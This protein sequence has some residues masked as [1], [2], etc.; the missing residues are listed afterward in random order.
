MPRFLIGAPGRRTVAVLTTGGVFAALA[1]VQVGSA[2]AET[3]PGQ[4][5]LGCTTAG[6][7]SSYTVPVTAD[8]TPDPATAGAALALQVQATV[9]DLA[10]LA[11]TVSGVHL[12]LPIPA[13]VDHV[14]GVTFTGGNLTGSQ[15]VVGSTVEL[16][17]AGPA[18]SGTVQLPAFTV[19]VVLRA[20]ST[21]QTVVWA[22][23]TDVSLDLLVGDTIV[24]T[25]CAPVAGSAPL[26]VT[27]VDGPIPPTT[28]T[29]APTTTTTAPTTTTTAPTTTTTAPTT[30]ITTT[31]PTTT[32]TRATT[33]TTRPTTTTRRNTTTTTRRTTTTRPTTTTT[34]R[35]SMACR[36]FPRFCTR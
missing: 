17:F 1:L 3:R 5:V 16:D 26:N 11:A 14:T 10:G 32:T 25:D 23:P 4:L 22:P 24:V 35:R 15:R 18:D 34:T 27:A 28:T 12:S 36:L 20:D 30:T 13:Q 7:G 8:D 33:T 29:T 19:Q 21:S 2:L 6:Y 9:P 31:R